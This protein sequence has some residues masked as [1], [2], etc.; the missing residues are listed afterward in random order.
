MST[1]QAYVLDGVRTPFCKM[2]SAYKNTDTPSLATTTNKHLISSLDFDVSTINE[3]V[4]GCVCQPADAANISRV[5]SLRSGVP[6][7]VP[8]YTVH[9]NCASGL[10]A[11]TQCV[12]KI[13]A[14]RGDTY[15][16]VGVE[17]MS[18]APL[19][20]NRSATEKFTKLARCKSV[21]SAMRVITSFR[22]RDF[23]PV[24]AL[25][26]GLTDVVADMNMGQTAELIA[27]ENG[28]TRHHQDKFAV[29]SHLKAQAAHKS[30]QQEIVPFYFADGTFVDHDNGVRSSQNLSALEKLRPVFDRQGTITAGN[31]SQ[32]TDGAVS[33]MIVDQHAINR[34]DRE[35]LGRIVDYAYTGCDPKRMGLGP[36][37][38]IE[39]LCTRHGLKL[40]DF[41][42]IEI[43]EA[44]AA[45]VL[46]VCN[47]LK[48]HTSL[49][50]VD[51]DKLNVNGGSIAIGHPVGASGARL[52]LTALKELQRRQGKRALVSLCV[53]GG[54]GGAVILERD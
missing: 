20:Y 44:F 9:R 1:K 38:A 28:V 31:A 35:P 19:L 8:A 46:A 29:E 42:L 53:G 37:G 54:Q 14:S 52:V 23:S 11:I 47:Q 22:F 5:I 51:T 18:N 43:N 50:Q 16:A 27:R 32:I 41:D 7:S 4:A 36:V 24:V 10:E 39:T 49:G 25:R 34:F 40:D 13:V 48:H 33:L 17:S 6:Q 3:H 12:D 45:Q 26:L 30:L 2:G 21:A 15:L